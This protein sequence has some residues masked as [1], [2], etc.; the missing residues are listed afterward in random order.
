MEGKQFFNAGVAVL[1]P[2]QPIPQTRTFVLPISEI[3]THL[4]EFL[5][6]HPRL[7]GVNFSNVWTE[8]SDGDK[9]TNV[10]AV[11]VIYF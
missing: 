10:Q 4:C 2:S 9:R 5:R 3:D 7:M 8:H 11:T 6:K 1:N